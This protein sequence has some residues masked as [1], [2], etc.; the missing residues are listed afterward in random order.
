NFFA[1]TLLVFAGL[2]ALLLFFSLIIDFWRLFKYA[3]LAATILVGLGIWAFLGRIDIDDGRP[4][5]RASPGARLAVVSCLLVA[6]IVF[7]APNLYFSPLTKSVNAQVTQGELD[8]MRWLFSY[9][10]QNVLIQE[11]G[12]S[13]LRFYDVL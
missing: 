13:Q 8:G 3:M 11:L 2:S 12:I 4:R 9:R 10:D 7:S 6:G 1:S 5:N